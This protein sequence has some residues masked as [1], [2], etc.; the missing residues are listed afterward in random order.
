MTIGIAIAMAALQQLPAILQFAEQLIPG[1]KHGPEKKLTAVS[2][3][4]KFEG[5]LALDQDVKAAKDTLIDAQ[6]RYV[7]AVSA[8]AATAQQLGIVINVPT[9]AG[10]LVPP[11]STLVPPS[12]VGAAGTGSLTHDPTAGVATSAVAAATLPGA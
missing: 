4:T 10:V 9:P 11:S 12:G 8:A 3:L 6:V 5:A 2:E 1:P 7:N